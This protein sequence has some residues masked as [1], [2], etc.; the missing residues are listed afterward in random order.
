MSVRDKELFS[1]I[2]SEGVILPSSFIR[3]IAEKAADIPGIAASD[4]HYG[5]PSEL[6]E[7]LSRAWNFARGRWKDFS[8]I[9]KNAAENDTL[10]TETREKWLLPLLQELGYGRLSPTVAKEIAGK[11]YPISHSWS[12]LPIHLVGA[13]VLIDRTSRGV[14]GASRVSPHGLVQEFLNRDDGALW[15][16]VSNGLTFRVLRDNLSLTKASYIEFDLEGMMEGEVYSDFVVFWLLCHV[17]RVE[18]KIP[19]DTFLEKWTRHSHE[20]GTRALD[21]L[22]DGVQR[23]IEELGRGFISHP[24]NRELRAVLADGQ[25]RREDFY[26]EL[27]RVVYRLIFLFVA[28]DRDVLL[29]PQTDKQTKSRYIEYYSTK[30]LRRIAAKVRGTKHTDHWRGLCLLFKALGSEHGCPELG[31]PPLGSFLWS[32]SACPSLAAATV[33]N[34]SLLSS[35]RELSLRIDG[36]TKRVVDFK[37]LGSEELGSVYESLLEL[38]PEVDTASGRFELNVIS[39]NE[40]KTTGSY[41]TP[42]SLITCLL[43]SALDPVLDEKCKSANPEQAILSMKVCDPACGSGHFLIAAAHRI[44]GRLARVRSGDSEPSPDELRNALRDVIGHCIYGVDINPMAVELCKVSLWLE[45]LEPGKPLSFLENRIQCGN[46]LVGAT[47]RLLADGIPNAAFEVIEGDDKETVAKLKKRNKSER[48]SRE[49]KRVQTSFFEIEASQAWEKLG[50]LQAMMDTLDDVN[51][52]SIQGVKKKQKIYEEAVKGSSYLFSKFW[53]D[54]WC[55]A[56]IIEKT[57]KEPHQITDE[58]FFR[59]EQNPYHVSP[60]FHERI[61]NIAERGQFL[62]WHVAFPG[63]FRWPRAGETPENLDTGWSGGFDVVLGNPPWEAS[64]LVEKEFFAASAPEITK[65]RT[66]ARRVALIEALAESNPLL[67]VAWRE[68]NRTHQGLTALIKNSGIFPLGACGKLNTYRVFAELNTLLLTT[69]GRTGSVLKSGIINAQDSQPYFSSLLTN[70]RVVFVA[71]FINTNLIFRDIVANERFCVLIATGTQGYDSPARYC[72][73]LTRIEQAKDPDVGFPIALEELSLINPNDLSVPPVATRKDK[74]LL[75]AIHASCPALVQE[76]VYNGNPWSIRYT[77]GHLNS[78]SDSGLFAEN[79]LEQLE[80]RGGRVVSQNLVQVEDEVF[81]PLYEGKFIAQ[82][83]HRFGSFEGVAAAERFGTKAETKSPTILQLTEPSYEITPRYWLPFSSAERFYCKKRT[84]HDWL[85]AFRDVCRAI[86]DA[87]TVQACVMPRLPCLDGCPLMVFEGTDPAPSVAALVFNVLWSSFVYDFAARQKIHGAHLTKAIAYQLPTIH[88]DRL[89]DKFLNTTILQAIT[90]HALELTFVS[91]SLTRF[92]NECGYSGPPFR[93]DEERRFQIR[94]EL[95]A[96]F[97]HIYLGSEEDWKNR[98]RELNDSF[99][100]PREAADYILE[101]FPIVKRKEIAST[102]IK[103]D[104]GVVIREGRYRS[105]DLIM[106]I[107]DGISEA[108]RGEF[109][110]VTRL[111]PPPGPPTNANGLFIPVEHWDPENWPSHI[112]R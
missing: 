19:E 61:K 37:N 77:Q 49:K 96:I 15:A 110:Y 28:D 23:A 46:S 9:R 70:G 73:G 32:D 22:R 2:R 50:N 35:I 85:F 109:P 68:K 56:F 54:T 82:L 65:A 18:G 92:A 14:K 13:G 47:P 99:T 55:A 29:A 98:G 17:S 33:T 86:V 43:D 108:K 81:L 90:G 75:K 52:S 48:E 107:Y 94:C 24:Q 111:N 5:S 16:F 45:A 80:A 51:D 31:L 7:A 66:K 103:N 8:S 100:T 63:V 40:R 59:I 57:A 95:D 97:F 44:A 105:K 30:R 36:R 64:D 62:H 83:N 78:A 60:A 1:T 42:T 25:L 67:A 34:S 53:A 3:R 76:K 88:P 93:W 41:Y 112:N 38:A 58:M 84:N 102:E 20:Q 12:H 72:F 104:L 26:K 4:Y 27:L 87:R 39:G 69:R 6:N 91:N 79:T 101:S 21:T 11:S 106:E 74:A 71:E 10:T 89:R